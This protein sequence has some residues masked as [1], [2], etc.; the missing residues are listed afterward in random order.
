MKN[1]IIFLIVLMMSTAS[2][3][4]N[5]TISKEIESGKI[6][7]TYKDKVLEHFEVEMYAVHYGNQL[8]FTKVNDVITIKDAQ[9][10]NATIKIYYKNELQIRELWYKN[11]VLQQVASIAFDMDNLP[12]NSIISRQLEGK[13]IQSYVSSSH[14]EHIEYEGMDKVFKLFA[15]LDYATALKNSSEAFTAIVV[16]FSQEDA[17]LRIYYGSYAEEVAPQ[18]I[19]FI[20][21]NTLGKIDKGILW[22]ATASET[23]KYD[24]YA[25]G[26]ISTTKKETLSDYQET[27]ME[28]MADNNF[29]R[30]E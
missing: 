27:I 18:L 30:E 16:I 28:Y 21:T 19:G 4:Q 6:I 22:K 1:L 25:N 2:F 13:N 5:E 9:S 12:K 11:K 3:G 17:L 15:R 10:K 14:F 26:K 23:G 7:K 20:Q 8:L 29:F 24:I